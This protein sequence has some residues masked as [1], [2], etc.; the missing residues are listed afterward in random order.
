MPTSKRDLLNSVPKVTNS[1]KI[2][3]VPGSVVGNR[4][5]IIQE[6]G[7]L[8]KGK[9]YLAKDLQ[10]TVDPRCVVER[11]SPNCDNEANWQIIQQHLENEVAVLKR[12]GDHPQIPQFY[13]Y[14][15]D[16]RQFYLVRE[17]IDGDNLEQEV[18]RKIFDEADV[19]Y[20]IQDVLRI[21]DFIH[22]TN[23]IHRDI[24]PIHLIR[25]KQDNT[26]VLIDF[27]A[28]GE[29]ESTKINLQGELIFDNSLD[30]WS[31]IAP[32]QKTGKSHFNSD[33]YAL[34]RTAIYAV[35]G[36]SPQELE[37]TNLNWQ[38]QCQISL[39]L[40]AIL[41]KMMSPVV[42]QRYGSALEVLYDLRPLLKI[43]QV[44]GGRYLITRYLGG[45][46]EIET[47]LADNL[48]RQYQ[49]PCLLKQIEL[50]QADGG[51][52]VKIERHF[53]EELSVLERL[54][55]H[56]QIPQ[57]WDHFQEND[58]FYLV[59]EY[60][61][62]DNLAQ[63]IAQNNIST[64]QIIQILVSALSILRFI[65]QNRIIH[66]NIKPS[67][68]IIRDQD[69]QIILTDFGILADIKALPNTRGYSQ[70][71]NKQNYW[72][73]EQIAGRP[74][75]TSDIYALGMTV[76]EALT[77]A[78]PV[79]LSRKE[80][81]GEL[82][83]SQNIDLDRRLIKIIN[84]MVQL[85]LGRRYQSAEKIL[86]DLQRINNYNSLSRLQPVTFQAKQRTFATKISILPILVGLL[87]IGCLLGSI[88][89]AFP[90]V[91]P[92]YYWYQGKKLLP[93]Q[94]QTALNSFIKAI[95]LKPQ[96]WL[97]WSGRGDALYV[98]ER[99]P[100]ALEAYVEA[101]K[102]NPN[103][104]EIWQKQGNTLYRLE[105]FT[106]AIAA[107]NRA[108]ELEPENASLYNLKGK[109]LY[110]LQQYQ[111]AL[112]MQKAALEIDRLDAQFL[113]DRAQNLVQ[114]GEYYDA[115]TVFNR[116][117]A[118]EP[119]NLKLWQ[120]KFLVLKA[121][122]R[123]QEAERVQREVNNNYIQ[124]LQQQPRNKQHWLEQGDFFTAAGMNQKALESY[125]QAIELKPNMYEAW[126]AKGKTLTLL[127]Q[128]QAALNALDKALQIR[129][130]SY[131]ALQAKGSVYQNQSNLTEAIANYDR[132]IEINPNYAPLWR[133]QGLALNQQ[134]K[135]IQAIESLTTASNLTPYDAS[136][137]QG[138]AEAWSAMDQNQK[139]LSAI[140]RAIELRPQNS[141]FWSQKGLIYSI[142]GQYNEACDTYRQSRQATADSSAIINSMMELGCRMD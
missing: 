92:V 14:F 59:Q 93:E 29:I 130:Q 55:Y 57:L 99:Y 123:P 46:G 27:A 33:I 140:N 30:N 2:M 105:R 126:L 86:H 95:D 20:L 141:R 44:V 41:L 52:K 139:A 113:S 98:L 69:G 104:A 64:S 100:Q 8:E 137:W 108:L 96:S 50:P 97:A 76:I 24:Q 107:Y 120:N 43:R 13:N 102:L 61:R 122:N 73:P 136:T 115:L 66:R 21:L 45:D 58:E 19:I 84:K 56:E 125:N 35:T 101:T 48:H 63:K 25:R 85:D 142:N 87:G 67:N 114:L 72:S 16:E 78:K 7:R 131:L 12:I 38:Q 128:D 47:Y 132:A 54:G 23:V 37:Q 51:G 68:L 127:G 18:T 89:F 88:E 106:E 3:H 124:L 10:T 75:I 26:F 40:E 62:G 116:V 28:I 42:E 5:Q 94:P 9:T 79:T 117:Q 133:D 118:I 110:Q 81:T 82:V 71:Q 121:L 77:K 109:A 70:N 134:T 6:L 15:V 135:Y 119:L 65:H 32:E 1:K 36:R 80:Q 4:Y 53:A 103:K 49:S 83:W 39:K 90:T 129:S 11:L 112:T 17:Y 138:L 31:Y 74:T 91:R 22:K 34:A 111:A 60:I